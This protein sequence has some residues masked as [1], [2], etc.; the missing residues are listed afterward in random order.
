MASPHVVPDGSPQV[1]DIQAGLCTLG[2][3]SAHDPGLLPGASW[4]HLRRITVELLDWGGD[5]SFSLGMR[6]GSLDQGGG[7][8]RILGS[9]PNSLCD[10]GQVSAP[11]SS[12]LVPKME[13]SG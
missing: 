5:P 8:G 13:G 12:S 11:P 3:G 10:L 9:T 1:R 7:A 4:K 6:W 2:L